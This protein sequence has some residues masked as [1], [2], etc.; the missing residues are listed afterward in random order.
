MTG[1]GEGAQDDVAVGHDRDPGDGR[2]VQRYPEPAFRW[3]LE[4]SGIVGIMVMLYM[5]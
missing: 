4:G 2:V 3:E 5:Y 1:V